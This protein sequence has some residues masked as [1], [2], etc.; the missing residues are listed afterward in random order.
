[1]RKNQEKKGILDLIY[2][3]RDSVRFIFFFIYSSCVLAYPT[4]YRNKGIGI[5][6]GIPLIYSINILRLVVISFV[7]IY[8][9]SLF[10]FFHVYLWQATFIIFVVIIFL[11]WIEMVVKH[12]K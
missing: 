7:Q 3:N 4:T 6:I 5:L 1:M 11:L 2:E 9:P 8:S 12:G 10:E